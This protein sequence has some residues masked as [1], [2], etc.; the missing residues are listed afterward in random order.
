MSRNLFLLALFTVILWSS[1]FAASRAS[2]LGGYAPGQLMIL[3]YLT[4]S[5]LFL[6]YALVFRSQ[7]KLPKKEDLPGLTLLALTGVTIYQ[8]GVTFGQE[9]VTAGTASMIVSSAPIFTTI[10]AIILLKERMNVI[11][12]IGL[13]IGFFGIFLITAGTTGSV[14]SFSKG[15]FYI[16]I[17]TIALSFFFVFQKRF[18]DSYR[19]I[20]LTA[21]FTWIGTIPMLFYIPGLGETIRTATLEATLS[22]IYI[23]IVPG[24]IC[25]VL[26][27]TILRLGNVSTLTSMLYLEPPSAIIIA[28]IWLDELPSLLSMF[29]GFVAISSV[30]LVNYIDRKQQQKSSTLRIKDA[31]K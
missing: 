14:F 16:L 21:Y 12:W 20:E 28:W 17:A 8:F 24:A 7:F 4:A 10:I 9:T 31:K 5:L 26:W 19:P 29:G 23:G 6:I 2:L 3:R 13:A 30:L 11:S 27:T 18:A 15:I 25:Y 1:S 22:A